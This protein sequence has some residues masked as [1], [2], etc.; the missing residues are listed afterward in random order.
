MSKIK[1][2]N[3]CFKKRAKKHFKELKKCVYIALI[4]GSF[5]FLLLFILT[6]LINF[7]YIFS[8]VISFLSM[9]VLSFSLNRAYIFNNFNPKKLHRQYYE[10]FL[11]S[12][13]AFTVNLILLYIFVDIIGIYYLLSQLFIAMFGFPILF[14]FYKKKVFNHR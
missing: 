8:F 10:F 14:T 7:N 11:V 9:T 12:L 4:N 2:Y 3:L 6:S 13:G 1:T 5:M